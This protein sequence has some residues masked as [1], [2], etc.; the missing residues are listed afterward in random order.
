[1]AEEEAAL[2][3]GVEAGE[4]WKTIAEKLPGRSGE[5]A[6]FHA[7]W[8]GI[9][10]SEKQV[11]VAWTEAEDEEIRAGVA[12]GE[13]TAES[14]K[15]LPGRTLVAVQARRV[16]LREGERRVREH[17]TEAEDAALREGFASGKT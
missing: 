6:Q 17:W 12:V 9:E 1:M 2:R 4:R 5:A 3:A 10:R 11:H 7:R 15:R 8:L 16:G 13:N 14:A